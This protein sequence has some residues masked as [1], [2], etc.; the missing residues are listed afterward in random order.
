[1]I[2]VVDLTQ[3]SDNCDK[4]FVLMYT[5]DDY[6]SLIFRKEDINIIRVHPEEGVVV[7][8]SSTKNIYDLIEEDRKSVFGPQIILKTGVRH[9][10]LASDLEVPVVGN[11]FDED[12]AKKIIEVVEMYKKH[13]VNERVVCIQKNVR[14]WLAQRRYN[15]NR[16]YMLIQLGSLPP[17]YIT[18]SFPG[19]ALYMKCFH[20]FM[21]SLVEQV[22]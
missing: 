8:D 13:F 1:M 11:V 18:P 19:G 16:M 7:M 10:R 3:S 20:S 12:M 17:K 2:R 6:M 22:M 14:R 5:N 4:L 21:E 9:V 15:K